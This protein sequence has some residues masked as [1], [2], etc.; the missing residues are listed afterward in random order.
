MYHKPI[1]V[2][3]LCVAYHGPNATALTGFHDNIVLH[4]ENEGKK[5]SKKLK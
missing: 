4:S 1:G 5:E 3:S 2:V